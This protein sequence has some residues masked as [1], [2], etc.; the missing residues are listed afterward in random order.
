MSLSRRGFLTRTAAATVAFLTVE[1]TAP[2]TR[3]AEA[4]T[5]TAA[6]VGTPPPQQQPPLIPAPGDPSQWPAWRESLDAWRRARIAELRYDDRLYR[7]REF[8]W[9]QRCFSC[10][11]LMLND[12]M[13]Y[14]PAKRR[15]R[16]RELL[17]DARRDFGGFDAVVLWHAY[18]RIGFDDRNQFDFYRDQPGGLTGLRKLARECRALECRVFIDYNPWDTGT[19]R[20]GKSDIEALAEFVGAIE[21]DGIF[22]DTLD[23]GAGELRQRL[24]AARPGVVLESELALPEGS[25]H[26]NH[27]SWGQWFGDSEAPGVLR[28]KW[29]E[30]RH[31]QHAIRRWDTDHTGEI[32]QAWMNGSGI[33]VWE[34]VFGMWRGWEGSQKRLLRAVLPVQRRFWRLFSNPDTNWTP[35]VPTSSPSIY[36]S[37][38]EQPGLRLWTVVNRAARPFSGPILSL[39]PEPGERVFDV[40]GAREIQTH[41]HA[42]EEIVFETEIPARGVA[43]LVCAK[44]ESLGA[45]WDGFLKQLRAAQLQREATITIAHPTPKHEKPTVVPSE[46][47]KAKADANRMVLVSVD[48]AAVGT[49]IPLRRTMQARECGFTDSVSGVDIITSRLHQP[50]VTERRAE[51]R[52]TYAFDIAPVTNGEYARFLTASGYRPKQTEN[53]L[54]HWR[55]SKPP[56]GLADHPVVYVDL[57]DARAYAR[58]A[59]KRLPTEDEWQ[60]AAAGP[61]EKAYPWGDSFA[62]DRCNMGQEHGTT[63]VLAFPRGRSWCGAMDLCGNVWEWTD[64]ERTDGHTRFCLLKGGSWYTAHGSGWYAPGGPQKNDYAAKFLLHWPGLDRCGTIGFRCAV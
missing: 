8:E 26:D 54:K 12:A 43:C 10:A 19:R 3:G 41:T 57:E 40:L 16:M 53:F 33:M 27:A 59:G 29:F 18:P 51:L 28:N 39:R 58:W 47:L 24:D 50:H 23:R 60:Y 49:P 46:A 35:L 25:V 64:S 17:K 32:Q 55:G 31:M 4:D 62:A 48:V 15:T 36:A 30:R 7:L 63:P 22:L 9:A 20:E 13:V 5:P 34:N 45:G 11:F 37:T 38:W 42:N 14:D 44:P 2:R 56:G 1:P 6:A 21:A 61:S 52:P